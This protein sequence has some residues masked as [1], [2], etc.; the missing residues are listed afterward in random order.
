MRFRRP[1]DSL[2]EAADWSCDAAL[3]TSHLTPRGWIVAHGEE[4][5]S[6]A[7]AETR[8][9]TTRMSSTLSILPPPLPQTPRKFAPRSGGER[10]HREREK[11]KS[12]P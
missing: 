8:R 10:T 2:Q 5:T 3:R 11:K 1:V 7:R 4:S 6:G 9:C 12:L